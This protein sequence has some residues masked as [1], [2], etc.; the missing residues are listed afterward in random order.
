MSDICTVTAN[1]AGLP[2]ITTPCGKNENGMPVAFQITANEFEERQLVAACAAF[3][4]I[5]RS[6]R[7]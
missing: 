4:K 1:I 5:Y 6:I 7:Q 3:E 2:A